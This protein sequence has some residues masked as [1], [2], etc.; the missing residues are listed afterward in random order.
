MAR[1]QARAGM[2]KFTIVGVPDALTAPERQK[3]LAKAVR[4][5]FAAGERHAT[6]RQHAHQ[7]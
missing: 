1:T 4:L 3:R 2:P 7:R 6:P 5:V